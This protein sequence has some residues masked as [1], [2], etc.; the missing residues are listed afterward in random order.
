[1]PL[2]ERIFGI[3][4]FV[5]VFFFSVYSSS[6]SEER[7]CG[8][9]PLRGRSSIFFALEKCIKSDYAG[10]SGA[11]R[12]SRKTA[13]R[14]PVILATR[15]IGRSRY[16]GDNTR[17]FKIDPN[18]EYSVEINRGRTTAFSRNL[19]AWPRDD[20]AL[21]PIGAAKIFGITCVRWWTCSARDKFNR[22]D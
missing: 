13:R 15:Y 20:I 4:W 16:A 3:I 2:D 8:I 12:E 11:R 6:P 9:S 17:Y 14:R 22:C 21:N 5:R 10:Y 1:M 19:Y 7:S 18:S